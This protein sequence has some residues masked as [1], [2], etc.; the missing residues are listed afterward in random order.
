MAGNFISF[1]IGVIVMVLVDGCT[2]VPE[3]PLTGRPGDVAKMK[4][5]MARKDTL[6]HVSPETD[7]G[8]PVLILLHGATEDPTE[9]MDIVQ[10][11]QGRYD[12]YL[13]AYNFH[14]RLSTVAKDF[15]KEFRQLR[16]RP[17]HFETW[18]AELGM[19]VESKV[20]GVGGVAVTV[21]TFSYS[22]VVFR[23]AVILADDRPLFAQTSL[24]Q[25]VPL[26]GGSSYARSLRN[27]V[28]AWVVSRF[29][30]QT[31]AV[32]PYGGF[33]ERLWS[34]A[35]N[36]IFYESITP[37]RMHSIL[38][39]GDPHSLAKMANAKVH[40]DYLNGIG[41]NVVVIPKCA[42]ICH[43]YFPT[44]PAALAYLQ[45]CLGPPV[46]EGTKLLAAAGIKN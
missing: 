14:H 40:A 4:E 43:D 38:V 6:V 16:N 9:M 13:F 5:I 11:W 46:D 20:E 17:Q 30:P 2:T 37:A 1:L 22:S 23:E 3:H 45:Q 12:V 35:G 31:Q 42:D 36:R 24:I 39:E 21:V 10:E 7:S 32:I 15:V 41:A 27:P 44:E 28:T 25:L 18:N 8:K 34:G 19:P 26:A 29:S 33:A